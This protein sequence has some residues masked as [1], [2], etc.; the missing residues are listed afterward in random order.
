MIAMDITDM[1][2]VMESQKKSLTMIMATVMIIRKR[3][4]TTTPM[5]MGMDTITKVARTRKC[6]HGR[7]EHSKVEHR[8]QWQRRLEEVG[9]Q[10]L[11]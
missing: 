4:R 10:R 11:L 3:K 2:M 5:I 1:I 6:L 9:I 7:S 8:I